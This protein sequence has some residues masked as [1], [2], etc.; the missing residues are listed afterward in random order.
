M[1]PASPVT[2][3]AHLTGVT[4]NIFATLV[5]VDTDN[6]EAGD[7]DDKLRDLSFT[8]IALRRMPAPI[9]N[10]LPENASNLHIDSFVPTELTAQ[11]V[12]LAGVCEELIADIP[13][14][15]SRVT[16]VLFN[17]PDSCQTFC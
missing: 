4:Y 9:L 8:D 2:R 17:Y 6:Y 16:L 12:K 5:T 11:N 10:Q 13:K 15:L 3:A 7:P 14:P 1:T